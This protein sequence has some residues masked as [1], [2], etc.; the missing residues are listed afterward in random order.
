MTDEYINLR[1]Q[2]DEINRKIDAIEKAV[3]AV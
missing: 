1:A 3:N 2:R